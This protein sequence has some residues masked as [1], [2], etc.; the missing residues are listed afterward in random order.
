MP[1]YAIFFAVQHCAPLHCTV[2][3]SVILL[4]HWCY[5]LLLY[6]SPS[7]LAVAFSCSHHSALATSTHR[8]PSV[9]VE[10]NYT[11]CRVSSVHCL[12]DIG[13]SDTH[14][15]IP[16]REHWLDTTHNDLHNSTCQYIHWSTANDAILRIL[17]P[18]TPP[19]CGGDECLGSDPGLWTQRLAETASHA[20][21]F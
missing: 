11:H 20:S 18:C 17:A 8:S 16:R 2:L 1:C 13:D 7:L 4:G 19:P 14:N 15:R 3:Y 5:F 9:H 6:S 12:V 21:L 10:D